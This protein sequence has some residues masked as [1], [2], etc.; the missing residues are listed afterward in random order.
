MTEMTT[1]SATEMVFC[2]LKPTEIAL[3]ST[4]RT[5]EIDSDSNSDAARFCPTRVSV[6]RDSR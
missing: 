3:A 5:S 6:R 4:A 1:K 2:R